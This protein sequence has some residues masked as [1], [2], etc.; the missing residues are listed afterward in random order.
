MEL[1]PGYFWVTHKRDRT[2]YAVHRRSGLGITL[3]PDV[4]EI[5]GWKRP[6]DWQPYDSREPRAWVGGRRISWA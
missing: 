2:G 5:D 3:G 1:A 4:V 6:N